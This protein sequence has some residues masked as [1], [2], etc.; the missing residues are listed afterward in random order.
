MALQFNICD[1]IYKNHLYLHILYSEKY[2]FENLKQLWLSCCTRF[3]TYISRTILQLVFHSKLFCTVF[4][5]GFWDRF[6]NPCNI[7]GVVYRLWVG[8]RGRGQWGWAD[9][10]KVS[11]SCHERTNGGVV[12]S[13]VDRD[14]H[15][16]QD[17]LR[18]TLAAV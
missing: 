1:S 16:P 17:R 6:Y 18:W 3:A 13:V 7:R 14:A 15:N 10:P 12:I 4:T 8:G 9:K 5:A 2:H 11:P